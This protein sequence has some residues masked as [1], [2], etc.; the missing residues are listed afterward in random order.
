MD[1]KRQR[2]EATIRADVRRRL[3]TADMLFACGQ[4]EHEPALTIGVHRFAAHPTRHLPHQ[5]LTAG[6]QSNMRAAKVEANA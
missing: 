3:F 2:A 1:G 4:R 5:L 6:E